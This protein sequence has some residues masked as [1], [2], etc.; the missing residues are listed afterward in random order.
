MIRGEPHVR[1]GR[2]R[3]Q[4]VG[5]TTYAD[6]GDLM[7]ER[8]GRYEVIAHLADGGMGQVYLA[9]TGGLGGFERHVV[10]KTLEVFETSED[11]ATAMFLDEA[12][13]QGLLHHHH[14]AP[15]YEVSQDDHRLYL[16]M[17]YVHGHSAHGVWKRT[18]DLGAAL[19]I[20][21]SLTVTAAAAS[22]L[23]YAHTR[24]GADGQE[25]HIVHRDV[26]LSN[27]MIGFDGGVKLIDF[28]IAKSA[29]RMVQTRSG[30]V[31]GK[32]GY[33]SPEQIRG[34]EVDARTDV[35][36]LGIV[37]YELTTMRRAFREESDRA[38]FERIKAGALIAPSSF[39]PDYPRELERIVTRALRV[40]PRER[41]PDAETMRGE[42]ERFGHQLGL[43]LGDSAV[44]A[45]MTQLFDHRDEPWQ[46]RPSSRPSP[47][48]RPRSSSAPDISVTPAPAD[49]DDN[50]GSTLVAEPRWGTRKVDPVPQVATSGGPLTTASQVIVGGVPG[51]PIA[52]MPSKDTDGVTIV[53]EPESPLARSNETDEVTIIPPS[54][55]P[56]PEVALKVV[57]GELRAQT[58]GRDLPLPPPARPND[59]EVVTTVRDLPGAPPERSNETDG[60]TIVPPPRSPTASMFGSALPARAPAPALALSMARS[61]MP[62]RAHRPRSSATGWIAVAVLLAGAIGSGGYLLY[63]RSREQSASW[64]P[65]AELPVLA[66][67]ELPPSSPPPPP[68]PPAIVEERGSG[69]AAPVTPPA[70]PPEVATSSIVLRITTIPPEAT[71]FLDGKRLGKTPYEGTA[72]AEPG[73]H[74]MKIRRRGYALVKLELELT[75]D[76]T[77]SIPLKRVGL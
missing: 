77:R 9:R 57:I 20:D 38:T 32:V 36:A 44:A 46:A 62:M 76:V 13:L 22:G 21:F 72:D 43:A 8:I 25:L 16:V 61:T 70:S 40:D 11:D 34:H 52:S 26:T 17:D 49:D 37:L 4:R 45:V 18:L 50:T 41:Y 33:M 30:F 23:H 31:K 14:I 19:P 56:P 64:D 58:A 10:L 66:S 24:R 39:M 60:V 29:N 28:G 47:R 75:E 1:S 12:R 73:I 51:A 74:T 63:E 53:R 71:I 35:F 5:S 15:V 2:F 69:S 59:T 67:R 65:P 27:L 68:Q 3:A 54:D 42:L 55:T 6:G 7:A 48:P